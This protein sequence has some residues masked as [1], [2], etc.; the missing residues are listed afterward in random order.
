MFLFSPFCVCITSSCLSSPSH[1]PFSSHSLFSC[2][3][4]ISVLSFGLLPLF[5]SCVWDLFLLT[6]SKHNGSYSCALII[7]LVVRVLVNSCP[8]QLEQKRGTSGL[9]H[10]SSKHKN[11]LSVFQGSR[12]GS[13]WM[14]L[15]SISVS[16][17]SLASE[18]FWVF[19]LADATN[20][21]HSN[22][23]WLNR[24]CFVVVAQ[25]LFKYLFPF[26]NSGCELSAVLQWHLF[27]SCGSAVLQSEKAVTN[28]KLTKGP[29][30]FPCAAC[31]HRA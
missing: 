6:P 10:F 21:E 24:S 23:T 17:Q 13:F 3:Y 25:F 20:T 18:I 12:F 5:L 1:F 9:T 27:L 19:L 11:S 30:G 14:L 29:G 15:L 4:S 7:W 2:S 8:C 26:L 22:S 16:N 31:Q 28:S